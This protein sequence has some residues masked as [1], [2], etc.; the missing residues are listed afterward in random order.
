MRR[1]SQRCVPVLVA[2]WLV[3]W[4]GAD[5]PQPVSTSTSPGEVVR[6]LEQRVTAWLQPEIGSLTSRV[7][8]LDSRLNS[9]DSRLNT[10]DARLLALDSSQNVLGSRVDD[11]AS[12]LATKTADDGG[13]SA[14]LGGLAALLAAQQSRLDG[15]A[16]QMAERSCDPSPLPRDCSELPAGTAS[17]IQLLQPGLDRSAPPTPA[18][19]D[20]ESDGGGWTVVQRRADIQPRQEFY[21]GWQAYRE[22]FGELD[23]EFWWGLESLWRMTSPRDRRYQ[24]RVDLA[25][26]GGVRRFAVYQQFRVAS[27]ADG[28]R[29]SVANYSGD[30]GDSFS[31]H[32]GHRFTTRDRDH[33]QSPNNCAQLYKGAGWYD[34]CYRQN[35]NGQYLSG[36]TDNHNGVNW[37]HWR[38]DKYSVKDVVIKIRPA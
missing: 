16:A 26:F 38:G 14:R 13:L 8:A 7:E 36:I 1:L 15:W 33:D 19:C 18:Y 12:Q 9:V 34:H 35:L 3:S 22:G 11:L 2:L 32:N 27:E 30:A 24:M 17:G 28:Y 4:C 31:Y 6:L 23:R 37:N 10:L 25:D 29:L 20:L 5:Q 21:L